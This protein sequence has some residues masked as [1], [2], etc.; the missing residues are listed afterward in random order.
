VTLPQ[1]E[2]LLGWALESQAAVSPLGAVLRSRP[3]APKVWGW[4]QH[5]GWGQELERAAETVTGSLTFFHATQDGSPGRM[6]DEALVELGDIRLAIIEALDEL[7]GEEQAQATASSFEPPE[8]A[9][10]PDQARPAREGA[11]CPDQARPAVPPAPGPAQLI[12]PAAPHGAT[13]HWNLSASAPQTTA[14]PVQ[15][16]MVHPQPCGPRGS[17]VGEHR[18]PLVEGLHQNK[19]DGAPGPADDRERINCAILA[20]SRTLQL[21][22]LPGHLAGQPRFIVLPPVL[23]IDINLPADLPLSIIVSP[24]RPDEA[25]NKSRRRRLSDLPAHVRDHLHIMPLIPRQRQSSLPERRYSSAAHS[26][27]VHR[28]CNCN[29]FKCLC[30]ICLSWRDGDDNHKCFIW[31]A[32]GFG[33]FMMFLFVQ[34]VLESVA[35]NSS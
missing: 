2:P 6:T 20:L 34:Q 35:N 22:Y 11:A 17:W 27:S 29:P 5:W 25:Q 24:Y 19:S 30:C 23:D 1:H 32:C 21:A 8:G 4:D 12:A 33:V 14:L 10:C 7:G 16:S 3:C 15:A 31:G 13:L 26:N 28:C 18:G 9:A